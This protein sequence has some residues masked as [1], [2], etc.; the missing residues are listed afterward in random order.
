TAHEKSDKSDW[1]FEGEV[2]I[3]LSDDKRTK[4]DRGKAECEKADDETVDD[5]E[6]HDYDELVDKDRA[7]EEMPD[8]EKTHEEMAD[9]EKVNAGDETVDDDEKHDYDE[10]V[11]KDRADEEMPDTEKTNEEIADVEKVNAKKTDEEKVDNEIANDDQADKDDQAIDD[12]AKDDQAGALISVIQKKK[13]DL[14]SLSSSFSMSSYYGNYF[15]NVSFDI[16]LVGT[17]KETMDTNINSIDSYNDNTNTIYNSTNNRSPNYYSTMMLRLSELEKKVE[18]LSKDDN[19]EVIKES[20][21]ANVRNEVRNHL[22]KVVSF[23][24][25]RS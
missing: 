1:G 8:T 23:L 7:D 14:P 12:K 16:S 20:I 2:E 10:L 24:H 11:D 13:L 9:V 22:P 5:D 15:L 21:Q 17:V 19:S 3:L 4:Y 25:V 18:A 6:K